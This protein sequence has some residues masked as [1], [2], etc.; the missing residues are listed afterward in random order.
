MLPTLIDKSM[1]TYPNIDPVALEIGPLL[2]RW[3][4]LAYLAG[5]LIGWVYIKWLDACQPQP[6][7]QKKQLD[8]LMIWGIAGII[9]GGRL[10]Y[11]LFYNF[12][13]FA[14]NPAE[15]I[16]IWRGG[17]SFHGGM[18]GVIIMFY[19]FSR[20]EKISFLR[21]IDLIAAAAPIGLFFG[22][23]ANFING[24]LYGRVTGSPF[25]MVFPHGGPEPRHPSQLYEA[26]LE[27]FLLF[28]VLFYCARFTKLLENRPGTI[29]A[30]FLI[31]YGL[32]RFTVEFFREPDAQLGFLALGF[33]MGQW[34]SL[35]MML[36]GIVA[37]LMFRGR[38][39]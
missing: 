8:D 23:L 1:L 30:I 32:A 16:E 27:G 38:T 11:V 2:I 5:I 31:G 33:S 14:E 36:A 25:G 34:L 4:A 29:G 3:Y 24:E 15:I 28:L 20:K 39:A 13:Y 10:G 6:L 37:L 19:L 35:P 18:L 17:M 7:L 22:R 9:L 26:A 12:P 21:L